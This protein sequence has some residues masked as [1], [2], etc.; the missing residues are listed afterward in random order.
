MFQPNIKKAL[1]EA[2]AAIYFDDNSDYGTALWSVIEALGGNEVADLL[3]DDGHA[4]Y[5]LYCSEDD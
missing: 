5:K 2:V 1:S 3:E 4:A